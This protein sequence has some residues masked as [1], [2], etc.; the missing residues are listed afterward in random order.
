MIESK[1]CL[2]MKPFTVPGSVYEFS[3]PA[4]AACPVPPQQ[5]AIPT[6]QHQ[7]VSVFSKP[8]IAPRE[9]Q[10]S[11]IPAEDL[12]KMCEEFKAEVFNRAGK[13]DFLLSSTGEAK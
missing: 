6:P 5:F 7:D 3:S 1:V 11:E 4:P 10:L 9:F 13:A 8:Y 12:L 2:T